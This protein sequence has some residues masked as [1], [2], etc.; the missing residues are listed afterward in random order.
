MMQQAP[1]CDVMWPDCGAPGP[2]KH[3][4]C[5][6][7]LRYFVNCIAWLCMCGV[8]GVMRALRRLFLLPDAMYG[9][10]CMPKLPAVKADAVSSFQN[11]IRFEVRDIAP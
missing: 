9:V 1:T 3:H 5:P 10:Y 8:T 4:S 7:L 6:A 11:G 2:S